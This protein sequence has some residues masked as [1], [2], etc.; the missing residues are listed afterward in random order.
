VRQ[1]GLGERPQGRI[2]LELGHGVRVDFCGKSLPTSFVPP[3]VAPSWPKPSQCCP[4]SQSAECRRLDVVVVGVLVFDG[5]QTLDAFGPLEVFAGAGYETA[6]IGLTSGAVVSSVGVA[7]QPTMS[8]D[9]ASGVVDTL[10]VAGGP[11]TIDRELRHVLGRAVARHGAGVRRI[12]SACTGAFVLAEAGLLDGQRCT[13][14]WAYAS[15]LAKEYPA[16]VVDVDCIFVRSGRVWTSAGVT[17]G[18]DLALAMVAD[19]LGTE[20]A[21]AIARHLVVYLQRPGGQSQFSQPM[22]VPMSARP[23]VND[24]VAWIRD[25]LDGDC[26]IGVLADRLAV[27]PRTLTRLFTD[28]FG[29]APGAFVE[30]CRFE[31]AR[32]LLETA[33]MSVS[34]I[35]TTV[36]IGRAE[37]LHRLF[38]RRAGVS[39]GSYRQ[40]FRRRADSSPVPAL[41]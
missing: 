1:L 27:S 41:H 21:R 23:D 32:H 39:P 8:I 15:S 22:R 2:R 5:F 24:L 4:C 12:A 20:T 18:I 26:S 38:Q 29:V 11:G 3:A 19:D 40:V 31:A 37:T 14:H 17:T 34:A 25:H 6:L 7:V 9:Q 35:A 16:V 10:V 33:D 30:Q 13:T 28:E 36:G